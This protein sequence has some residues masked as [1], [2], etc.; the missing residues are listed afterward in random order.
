MT[1]PL[2]FTLAERPELREDMSRI[3]PSVWPEFMLHDPVADE[4]WLKLYEQFAE[5]QF[6]LCDETGEA[7]ACGNAIPFAWASMAG[8]WPRGWDAVFECAVADYAAG[9][10]PDALSALQATVAKE[11]QGQGLSRE[12]LKGM[13]RIAA[14]RG[15]A[16]LVA[17]VRPSLKS[18]YPLTPIENYIRWPGPEGLLFDPWLRTHQRLGAEA[19]SIAPESMR[20]TGTVG[21]WEAWTELHFP[22]SGPYIVPGALTPVTIDRKRD[23]GRYVEPNVWMRHTLAPDAMRL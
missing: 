16:T 3:N 6:V 12:V 11:H 14:A 4:H 17:P 1:A 18:Q 9:R 7:L 22:E 23:C 15:F 13:R 20:I 8:Q 19:M 2:M 10:A 21:E 5:F